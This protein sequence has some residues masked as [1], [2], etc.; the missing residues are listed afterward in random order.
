V[1]ERV[2]LDANLASRYPAQL[3]G[4]EQQ[5]VAWR[6]PWPPIRRFC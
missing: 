3:S 1:L 2:G 4:G 5:R 6:A